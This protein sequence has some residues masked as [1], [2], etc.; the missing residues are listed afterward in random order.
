MSSKFLNGRLCGVK[1][2]DKNGAYRK[3]EL[4]EYAVE[5]GIFK[6]K[7]EAN[8][9]L[10]E[11][12]CDVLISHSKKKSKSPA[13][14]S[15]AVKLKNLER[16]KQEANEDVEYLEGLERKLS[17]EAYEKE[18]IKLKNIEK[19]EEQIKKSSKKISSTKKSAKKIL[20][21]IESLDSDS[22]AIKSKIKKLST[23]KEKLSLK[24]ERERQ[25]AEDD[26]EY[27][28]ELEKQLKKTKS[29]IMGLS[30]RKKDLEDELEQENKLIKNSESEYSKTKS[31]LRLKK[32][33][34]KENIKTLLTDRPS[35]FEVDDKECGQEWSESNPQRMKREEVVNFLIERR[36]L[37]KED[38]DKHSLYKLCNMA[39]NSG[40]SLPEKIFITESP[41]ERHVNSVLT[42]LSAKKTPVN[43]LKEL[44]NLSPYK[45]QID[46]EKSDI[47][48]E[49]GQ[50]ENV[51]NAIRTLNQE[52]KKMFP[53]GLQKELSPDKIAEHIKNM[54]V[55]KPGDIK[56]KNLSRLASC[57]AIKA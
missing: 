55:S 48:L 37:K 32:L 51:K 1:P 36:L 33:D 39:F 25:E 19:E 20:K 50:S 46:L 11:N 29:K 26:A 49:E 38:V 28:E 4:V 14:K 8:S 15:S 57:L 54:S 10:L 12:L 41:S 31:S 47:V 17:T 5:N 13:K 44:I 35:F 3:E 42:K 16:E 30:S 43:V 23:E 18:K 27:L 53:R 40:V 22:K 52:E 45:E 2:T 56:N 34:T 7:K 21:E 9:L 6:T 24:L